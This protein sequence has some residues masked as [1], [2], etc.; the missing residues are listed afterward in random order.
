MLLLRG[1]RR[2]RPAA[3]VAG[4]LVAAWQVLVGVSLAIQLLYLLA[5]LAAVGTVFWWRAGRPPPPRRIVLATTAGLAALA[6]VVVVAR[7]YLRVADEYP[8]VAPDARQ[9]RALLAATPGVPLRARP[10]TRLGQD[11]GRCARG[12]ARGVRADALPGAWCSPS[13]YSDCSAVWPRACGSDWPVALAAAVFSMGL[14]FLDG[15]SRTGCSSITRPRL[16]RAPARPAGSTRSRPCS[17]PCL[18]P[19]GTGV[20]QPRRPASHPGANVARA[21]GLPR[22]SSS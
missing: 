3:V 20:R 5:I 21:R 16:G 2:E 14:A 11:H 8:E 13:A 6:I 7:P 15:R 12:P 4:W 22:S 18:R 10:T 19:R 17:S 9:R 1:Y